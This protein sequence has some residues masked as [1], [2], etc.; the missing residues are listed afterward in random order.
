MVNNLPSTL[1]FMTG[2]GIVVYDTSETGYLQRKLI[3]AME[4]CKVNF[5]RSVRNANGS[6]IQFLY[7]DDGMDASKIESHPLPFLNDEIIDKYGFKFTDLKGFVTKEAYATAKATRTKWEPMLKTHLEQMDIDKD[8]VISKI[9]G[10]KVETS[11][12]YPVS[13]ARTINITKG[14]YTGGI[15]DLDPLY[16][17]EKIDQLCKELYVTD[18]H[19]G[20]YVFN[21]LAKI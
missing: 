13:I 20:N 9:F 5:D 6:I 7:G 14:L 17:L 11:I 10:C 15:V 1:N 4:D 12:M 18:L 19:K 16:I 3:K 8:F 2:C 21:I